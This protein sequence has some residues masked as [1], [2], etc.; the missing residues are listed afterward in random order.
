MTGDF[1]AFFEEVR[2][3]AKKYGIQAH[4]VCGVASDGPGKQVKVS[5][6]G[7]H[8]FDERKEAQL[9]KRCVDAM[10]ESLDATLMQLSGEEDEQPAKLMN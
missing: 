6:N 9:I 8:S 5:S 7:A 2:K 1:A 4:L 3:A 10:G